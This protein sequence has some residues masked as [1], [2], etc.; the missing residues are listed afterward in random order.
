MANQCLCLNEIFYGMVH[1]V[2]ATPTNVRF[3]SELFLFV[4][5]PL[6]LTVYTLFALHCELEKFPM[7]KTF[8]Y[9]MGANENTD[10]KLNNF[11]MG[12]IN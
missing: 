11:I 12:Q 1:S 9:N 7:E 4:F 5:K 10:F 6:I 8:T 3:C 2:A